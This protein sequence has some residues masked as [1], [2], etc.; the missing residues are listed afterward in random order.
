MNKIKGMLS[1]LLAMLIFVSVTGCAQ[2]G[3]QDNLK[4]LSLY[5]DSIDGFKVLQFADLHFGVEG[6]DY[7]NSDI[8]RSLDFIE[9]AIQT[10]KPDFIVLLGDNMMTQGTKGAEFIVKT[11]D[12]Y[13]IPYTLV[14]GN[15]DATSTLPKYKKADVSKYLETCD[16][17]YLLYQSGFTQG[18]KEDR[19]GNF[20]ISV[21]NKNTDEILG[22]FVLIDTGT[23]D[24]ELEQYQIINSEQIAWYEAEITR[25]N[26]IYLAQQTH[27]HDTI[28]S[29]NYG[30]I[31]LPEHSEAYQ[32]AM[33][34]NDCEIIYPQENLG[35]FPRNSEDDPNEYGFFDA[36]VKMKSAKAYLC[37]HYH[38]MNYHVKMDGIILGFCPQSAVTGNSSRKLKTFSYTL[39]ENFNMELKLVTEPEE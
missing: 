11:F 13:E 7:H 28:P 17:P 23:Y 26:E 25:L 29:I 6:E 36:M 35:W 19:Y 15:H 24:Y 38:V 27:A 22:A 39:D 34:G 32:K 16:S 8:Q 33:E 9:Y 2:D 5:V 37:G 1:C 21:K 12:Q 31:P 3:N 14:F 20:S 30:H 4:E 18:G 10:E